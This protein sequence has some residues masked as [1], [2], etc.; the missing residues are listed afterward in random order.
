MTTPCIINGVYNP[1]K[2]ERLVNGH[3]AS[4]NGKAAVEYVDG[5]KIWMENFKIHRG[6]NEPAIVFADGT[7]EWWTEGRKIK[8]ETPQERAKTAE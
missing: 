2:K 5:T 1:I 4:V 7:R 6:G 8:R 3:R